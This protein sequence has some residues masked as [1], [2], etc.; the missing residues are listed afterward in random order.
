MKLKISATTGN[1]ELEIPHE[2]YSACDI[3]HYIE[4]NTKNMKHK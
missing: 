1:A 4:C 2:S 3:Q